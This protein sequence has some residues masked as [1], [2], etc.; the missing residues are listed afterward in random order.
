M[1]GHLFKHFTLKLLI[2]EACEA[3]KMLMYGLLCSI[4]IVLCLIKMQNVQMEKTN[5]WF[6]AL[7]EM[8]AALSYSSTWAVVFL[9]AYR[10]N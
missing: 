5:S 3:D 7:L 2:F 10:E 4:C 1:S 6:G 9:S 8:L